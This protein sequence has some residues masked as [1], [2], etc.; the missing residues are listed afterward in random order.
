MIK[1]FTNSRMREKD[2]IDTILIRG[3]QNFVNFDFSNP[4]KIEDNQILSILKKP[5][6]V[7]YRFI[8]VALLFSRG[9]K[10]KTNQIFSA[11]D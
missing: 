10:N 3:Q 9:I 4:L 1:K 2:V 11:T 7:F 8:P 6:Q 5:R